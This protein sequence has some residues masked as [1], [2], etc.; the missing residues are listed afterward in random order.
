MR[1]QP[2][3][4]VEQKTVVLMSKA[5]QSTA[6]RQYPMAGNDHRVGVGGAGLTNRPRRVVQR[7]AISP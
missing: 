1:Q 6:R 3:L 7:L 2:A 4:D 5:A